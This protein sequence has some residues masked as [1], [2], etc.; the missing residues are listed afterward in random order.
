MF[1]C[2]HWLHHPSLATSEGSWALSRYRTRLRIGRHV[3]NSPPHGDTPDSRRLSSSITRI[4]T[5]ILAVTL[6]WSALTHTYIYR[7]ENFLPF[8]FDILLNFHH[9]KYQQA[10]LLP[11]LRFVFIIK[12]WCI[13]CRKFYFF[14]NYLMEEVYSSGTDIWIALTWLCFCLSTDLRAYR[15][16]ARLYFVRHDK[17]TCPH[18]FSSH[19]HFIY[20]LT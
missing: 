2:E 13:N 8:S 6:T 4:F 12:S 20:L 14:K 7:E 15:N 10:N 5:E 18:V 1:R 17:S 3:H 9:N 16:Y 19:Q 11:S